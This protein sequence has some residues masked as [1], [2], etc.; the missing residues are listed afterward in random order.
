MC[1]D[2]DL[3]GELKAAERRIFEHPGYR[4]YVELQALELS[5][6]AV[7]IPNLR[8]LLALLEAA[9]T[10]EELAIELIQNVHEPTVRD[11]FH[12]QMTQRLHNYLA[13]AHNLRDHVRRLMRD[14]TGPIAEEFERRKAALLQNP[15]VAFMADLRNYT[16]HR[17]LP[18]F[19]HT[20][21]M[22][23]VNTPERVMESEVQL[24]VAELLEGDRWTAPSRDYLKSQGDAVALRPV[25]HKHGEL[26]F[27]LNTWLHNELS[28]HAGIAYD[29]VHLL[30]QAWSSVDN[31]REFRA[32]AERLRRSR[33]R[34]VNGAYSLDNERQSGLAYPD[35][36]NDPSLSQAHLVFQ[37][38]HGQHRIVAPAPYEESS[39][40]TPPW[41]RGERASA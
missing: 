1:A 34:G 28:S 26:V 30:A 38:Q 5:I 27:H 37:V 20:L 29:E 35:M 40:R 7:F 31:P 14:R 19:A 4:E 15:E 3:S 33:Y 11:Q 23:K 24:N 8:E 13:G 32:V 39:F 10:N 2:R 41:C 25:V 16:L 36:T 6:T 21:S 9:S 12:A 22:T 18:F 17:K